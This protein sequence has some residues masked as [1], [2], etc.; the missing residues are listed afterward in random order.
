M[1]YTSHN[2]DYDIHIKFILQAYTFNKNNIYL[3]YDMYMTGIWPSICNIPMICQVH[4]YT[5]HMTGIWVVYDHLSVIYLSYDIYM[6]YIWSYTINIPVMCN[7]YS[8]TWHIIDILQI[9]CHIPVIYMSYLRYILFLLKV[10]AFNMNGIYY[11]SRRYILV[12]WIEYDCYNHCYE[13][14]MT[15]IWFIYTILIVGIWHVVIDHSKL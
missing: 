6:T 7:V 3:Q 5:L 8:W 12:I 15:V 1:S 9:E 13:K 4:E 11:S 10:Y 2:N 14:Y